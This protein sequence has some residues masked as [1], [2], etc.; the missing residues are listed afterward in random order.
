MAGF[1][2]KQLGLSFLGETRE[3]ERFVIAD[4]YLTGIE[5]DTN[6][7]SLLLPKSQAQLYQSSGTFGVILRME[8]EQ[9]PNFCSPKYASDFIAL[10]WLFAQQTAATKESFGLRLAAVK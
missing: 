9:A 7:S 8:C 4:V 5:I 2:R 1:V 6:V 10:D 3:T